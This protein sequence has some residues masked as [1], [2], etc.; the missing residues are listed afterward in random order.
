VAKES[1]DR[2]Q[3]LLGQYLRFM[4]FSTLKLGIQLPQIE[5][6]NRVDPREIST[7]REDPNSLLYNPRIDLITLAAPSD[8][9]DAGS[10]VVHLIL[11]IDPEHV[12]PCQ[13]R[14]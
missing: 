7:I 10:D 8:N 14:P 11:I 9:T 6:P 5:R 3:I 12:R 13:R 4:I 2:R 1:L